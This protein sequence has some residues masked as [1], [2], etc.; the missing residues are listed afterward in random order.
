MVLT[1]GTARGD[2]HLKEIIAEREY[3]DLGPGRRQRRR[4]ARR[5]A[6]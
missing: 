3:R 6:S 5:R 1:H 2:A 4:A